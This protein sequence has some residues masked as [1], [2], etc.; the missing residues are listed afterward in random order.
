[1][2]TTKG[3]KRILLA[4]DGSEH[5]EAAVD[6]TIAL[7]RPPS[8]QVR[9]VHVWNLEVHQRHGHWD[10]E[11]RSEAQQLLDATVGRLT[12]GGVRAEGAILRADSGHI[13][14]AVAVAAK[15]FNADLVVVGSRGLSNWQ[16]MLK[17]SVSHQL[18]STVD[19]PLLIVRGRPSTARPSHRVLLA[20][21]GGDDIGPAAHAAIAAASAPGS[22]VL[23][24]HVAQVIVGVQGFAYVE[25]EEEIK[26]TMAKAIE[27][28]EDAGIRAEGVVPHSGPVADVIAKVAETWNVDLIVVGSSRMGDLGSLFLGSVSHSLLRATERPVLIAERTAN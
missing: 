27:L 26:A 15:D 25:P 11:V 22:E 23:V 19:C 13:A 2:N 28:I 17:H 4:T 8:A 16:S 24:V 21:A 12:T 6:A 9:V 18:L 1:M 10:V 14:A 20:I 7:G 3:F 5:A